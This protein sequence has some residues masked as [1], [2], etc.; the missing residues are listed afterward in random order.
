M[1]I[2]KRLPTAFLG[3]I[4]MLMLFSPFS[5][6]D[7]A[8][9]PKAGEKS[10]AACVGCHGNK[11]Q[12]KHSQW[13]NLAAQQAVYLANQLNAFKTG[14]RTNPMMQAVA[15]NLTEVD[16]ANLAAYFSALPAVTAGGDDALAKAGQEKA[17]MCLGCH[18]QKGEG[19]AAIPRLAGQQP[20]YLANQLQNFKQ[21][22]RKSGPMQAIA[23]NLS[24]TDMKELAAFFAAM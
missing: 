11:G 8:G 5:H 1:T 17:A 14:A 13:P 22:I 16:M 18:G 23:G 7:L 4:L 10:A 15:A 19:H 2:G 12:G 3:L 20:E 9:D 6:A 24:D 21:G